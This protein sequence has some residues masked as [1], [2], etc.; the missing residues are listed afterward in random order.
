MRRTVH[1]CQSVEGALKNWKAREWKSIAKSN[2][3][4]VAE[5]KEAFWEY[6]REG[7]RVI[8]IGE[9]CEG[10]SYQT[11]CP[12]HAHAPDEAGLLFKRWVTDEPNDEASDTDERR[13]E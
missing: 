3:V 13:K 2:G 9:A 1:V 12:G 11:G 6:M 4:T 10:F 5:A 8:P 7:K